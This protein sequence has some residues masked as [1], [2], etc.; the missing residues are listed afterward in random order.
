MD[1]VASNKKS[2]QDP[3]KPP[4]FLSRSVPFCPTR[5]GAELNCYKLA[6]GHG[7]II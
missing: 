5:P 7:V 4:F 1:I 2:N 6:Y 3:G